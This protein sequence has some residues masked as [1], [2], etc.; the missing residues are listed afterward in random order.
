MSSAIEIAKTPVN[1]QLNEIAEQFR[2]ISVQLQTI[3]SSVRIHEL[4]LRPQH[5]QWSMAECIVHLSLFTQAFLPLI[6]EACERARREAPTETG[7]Y[8]MDPVGRLL[9]LV[10]EPPARLRTATSGRFLPTVV[11]PLDQVITTFQKLQLELISVVEEAAGLNL[12][13]TKVVSPVSNRV[14]YNLYSCFLVIASHQRRHLWQAD[15]VRKTLGIG[16]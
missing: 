3:V 13:Q 15:E 1:T 4:N 12:N 2:T 7:A 10:L 9:T 14:R 16:N 6:R 5:D 11:E 8:R